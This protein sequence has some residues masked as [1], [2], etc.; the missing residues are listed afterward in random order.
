MDIDNLLTFVETPYPSAAINHPP[1]GAINYTTYPPT[2]ANYDNYF[3]GVQSVVIDSKNRLWVLDTGRVLTPGGVLVGA[4]Y[5]GPKLV[6]IDLTT[7]KIFQTIVF[8]PTVAYSDSYLNDVRFDLRPEITPS[9]KGVA[10]ITDSSSEGRNGIVI[11][12]LG[13]GKAW[14]HL[15]RL[16]K[17]HPLDQYVA[18]VQGVPLYQCQP[19]APY[20]YTAFGSDGITLSA[21][22]NTLYWK[23]VAGRY[24]YSIPT[25]YLRNNGPYSEIAAEE[26]VVQ[27]I[28]SG[29]TDGMETDT[30]NFIYHGNMEQDAVSF[31]NPKNGTDTLFVR[32][33]RINWVDTFS[34]GFDGY[35]YFT[36]NQLYL[37]ASFYPCTDRR[38]RPFSLLR[39]PLPDGGTKPLLL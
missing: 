3:I 27:H 29:V 21:D 28:E 15:D 36:N 11:V 9:G 23:L 2:G 14:R 8:E 6:G 19:N 7:D 16:S 33:P 5:G 34:T 22:G 32:D 30:N 20:T 25:S 38:Q 1:G 31:F 26:N 18:Y 13:T 12:D 24:L 37:M 4:A 10:Y 17:V 35:L 39:V